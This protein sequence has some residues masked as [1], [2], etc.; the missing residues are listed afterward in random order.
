[1]SEYLT[2]YPHNIYAIDTDGIKM[3]I[4]LDSKYLSDSELGKMKHE[5]TFESATFIAPKVYGGLIKNKK[6]NEL[7]E[8]V[9]VKGLKSLARFYEL[10]MILYKDNFKIYEH[11]KFYKELS[12]STI[13][14]KNT[15]YKLRVKRVLVFDGWGKFINTLPHKVINGK[16]VSELYKNIY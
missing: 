1:M 2:K 13:I 10:N 7:T 11:E 5:F 4:D 9:K 14:V 6:T 16:V 12:L 3:D 8:L 15:P